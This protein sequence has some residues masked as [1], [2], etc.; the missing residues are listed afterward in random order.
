MKTKKQIKKAANI[1]FSWR[2]MMPLYYGVI[3]I[4]LLL[5]VIFS[6]F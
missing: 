5:I 1:L 4:V 6:P 2:S 3:W